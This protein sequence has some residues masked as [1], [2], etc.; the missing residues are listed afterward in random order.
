MPR[1]GGRGIAVCERWRVSFENFF[2]DL[3]SR[4]SPKHSIDR[5][6]DDDGNYEPS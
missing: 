1:G 5:Y 4:P 2:A 6:P 3:G